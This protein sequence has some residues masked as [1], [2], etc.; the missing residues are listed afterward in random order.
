MMKDNNRSVTILLVED[1]EESADML[2]DFL[3]MKSFHVLKAYDGRQAMRFIED[4]AED[5]RLAILDI[6]V[7]HIDGKEI[8]RRIRNHPVLEEIPVIFLTAKDEERDEIE[9]LNLGADDYISKPASLN[10]VHAHVQSLMRRQPHNDARWLSYYNVSLNG[11]T[12]EVYAGKK[13]VD[14]TATEFQLLEMLLSQPKRVFSRQEILER[15][16]GDDKFVF[17]RTVDVHVK[18]IRIKLGEYGDTIKT[19]RGLGYGMNKD[20]DT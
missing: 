11:E 5:I 18:N 12:K 10:L 20:L 13:Q 19:Y 2:A 4:R 6:M 9:G 1:E 15:I 14:L 17:D 8:C 16:A 7:P 3:E